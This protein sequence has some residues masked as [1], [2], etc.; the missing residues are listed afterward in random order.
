[1]P[2]AKNT[3]SAKTK[4]CFYHLCS[5]KVRSGEQEYIIY[6]L[7]CCDTA[8]TEQDYYREVLEFCGYDGADEIDKKL[9]EIEEEGTFE[10]WPYDDRLYTDLWVQD[11]TEAEHKVLRKFLDCR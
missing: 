6:E 3:S 11:I 7:K 4:A 9:Q 8:L 10:E 5:I 1:M 2:N